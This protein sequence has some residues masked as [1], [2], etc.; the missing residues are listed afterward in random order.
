MRQDETGGPFKKAY[1][2]RTAHAV[3]GASDRTGSCSVV[4]DSRQA[5][6][7]VQRKKRMQDDKLENTSGE[8]QG[9]GADCDNRRVALPTAQVPPT[10]GCGARK[11][12]R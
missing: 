7:R 6:S 3:H 10:K 9:T 11:E 4:A 1:R 5:T 2:G 8:A 12:Q